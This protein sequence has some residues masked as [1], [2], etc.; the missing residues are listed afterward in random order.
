MASMGF[1]EA[2][3]RN[4]GPIL[5]QLLSL[6]AA[7][8]AL[9]E[10]GAGTGQH[11][12]HFAAA[13]PHLTWQATERAESLAPLAARLELCGLANLPPPRALDV[14]DDAW[15]SG[16]DAVYTANT[17]HIMSWPLVQKCLAGIGRMLP[18][19]GLFVCYG[20][21]SYEGRHTSDSNRHFDALLR[22]RDPASGVRDIT[23][24]GA[25]AARAGLALLDD[26]P[27]PANNRLLVWRRGGAVS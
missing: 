18:P 11:A 2:C 12:A 1:S 26:R 23:A 7:R 20:P 17:L 14:A 3:E 15:P 19:G 22:E 21:F 16:Y 4:K 13:M 6:C 24:V 27:M 5:E 10:I 8:Y 9:L 25:A